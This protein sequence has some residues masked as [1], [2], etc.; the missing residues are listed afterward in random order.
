MGPAGAQATGGRLLTLLCLSLWDSSKTCSCPLMNL[1]VS[2]KRAV[3]W[4]V[5]ITSQGLKGKRVS[6]GHC[7]VMDTALQIRVSALHPGICRRVLSPSVF[8]L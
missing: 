4:L 7:L 1:S 3:P 8:I 6:H 5:E 2:G